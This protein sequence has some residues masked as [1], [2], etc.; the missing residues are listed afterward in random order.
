[1]HSIL[2]NVPRNSYYRNSRILYLTSIYIY[3]GPPGDFILAMSCVQEYFDFIIPYC[4]LSN[5]TQS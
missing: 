2:N 1:M 4:R 3:E 5:D